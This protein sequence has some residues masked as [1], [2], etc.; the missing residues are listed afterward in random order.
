MRQE[1]TTRDE[2]IPRVA[3]NYQTEIPVSVVVTDERVTLT[4][5]ARH[6]EWDRETGELVA[7]GISFEPHPPADPCIYL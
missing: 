2:V 6:L 5:G 3:V 1:F 4:V 7:E